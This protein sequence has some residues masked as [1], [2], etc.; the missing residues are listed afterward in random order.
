VP[1]DCKKCFFC[2][3]GKTNGIYHKV[4]VTE[5]NDGNKKTG[6]CLGSRKRKKGIQCTKDRQVLSHFP[7]GQ[8]CRQCYSDH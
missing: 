5:S 8:Y 6:R 7:S 3:I 1:C 4:L 2:K